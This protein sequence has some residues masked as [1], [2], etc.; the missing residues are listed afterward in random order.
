[1]I[2]AGFNPL[3]EIAR[4][5]GKSVGELKENLGSIPLKEVQEA[6]I[7]ATEAGGLFHGMLEK[8]AEGIAGVQAK[9]AGAI[10]NAFNKIGEENEGAIKA[11]FKLA[12][13]LIEQLTK[14]TPLITDAVVAFGAYKTA[15]I[16]TTTAE[17]AVAAAKSIHARQTAILRLAQLKLNA[18]IK[19]NPYGVA[20]ALLTALVFA[21]YKFVTAKTAAEKAQESF[22]K[23]LAD[24]NDL[25][26]ERRQKGDDA[27]A[28]IRDE[29]KGHLEQVQALEKLKQ[30]Y[31]G[32]FR[33]MDLKTAKTL[34]Q[35][36]AQRKLNDADKEGTLI[37]ARK[38]VE[39][40]KVEQ[41]HIAVNGGIFKGKKLREITAERK[42][43]EAHLKKLEEQAQ[44]ADALDTKAQAKTVREATKEYTEQIKAKREQI[45]ELRKATAT[46]DTA[47]IESLQKEI[48]DLEAK[49]DLL[50]GGGNKSGAASP[51]PSADPIEQAKK[52]IQARRAYEDLLSRQIASTISLLKDGTEKEVRQIEE[53]HRLKIQALERQQEDM[54]LTLKAEG[55]TLSE[56]QVQQF[57]DLKAQEQELLE[58]AVGKRVEADRLANEKI[59]DAY[60]TYHQKREQIL[61]NAAKKEEEIRRAA[62]ALGTDPGEHLE[63]LRKQTDEALKAFDEEQAQK[64]ATFR[65]WLKTLQTRTIEELKNA[66]KKARQELKKLEGAGTATA[67]ARAKVNALSEAIEE[68]EARE[69]ATADDSK[70]KWTDLAQ[71]LDDT[72][73][74]FDRLGTQIGGVAGAVIGTIGT[75]TTATTQAING[76][77][78]ITKAGAKGV[79]GTLK[80]VERASAILA[81]I[82]A[83]IQVAQK[84][85]SLFDRDKQK[86][87]EI[88][89]LQNDIDALRWELQNAQRLQ[90]LSFDKSGAVIAKYGQTLK[91]TQEDL[92]RANKIALGDITAHRDLFDILLTYQQKRQQAF[93]K[94]IA[95]S[96]KELDY[97]ITHA[98]GEERFKGVA[99]QI[100]NIAEQTAKLQQQMEA[101]RSKK[102]SDG[103]AIRSY[104]QQI[105]ENAL[106]ARDI[107]DK[108]TEDIM[109]GSASSI[110]G[111]LGDALLEAFKKGEDGAKAWGD[112]VKN[113][114]SDIVKRLM[115]SKLVEQPIGRIFD[116]YQKQWFGAN[117]EFRGIDAVTKS[118]PALAKELETAGGGMM[119]ALKHLS[120]ALEGVLK[121]ADDT[122]EAGET[123]TAERKGIATAGQDSIDELNGRATA[124]QGHTYTIQEQTKELRNIT[125]SIL[126]QVT[127]IKTN[128][129]T[130]HDIKKDIR[131]V[132]DTVTELQTKGIKTV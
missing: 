2:N 84:V 79:S 29:T 9:L 105:K 108:A 97:T 25:L 15:L 68:F 103:N 121:I 70:V 48:K 96:Y 14:L 106:K 76:I 85:A 132:R 56:E 1:M 62:E 120:P 73:R 27:L 99:K 98:L 34:S 72:A 12:N 78:V 87:E 93:A 119:E 89:G 6:F 107:I 21:I 51:K 74:A 10:Q 19:A 20:A 102:K 3:T 53:G 8:Q 81:V 71:T 18:A 28:V 94:A 90:N 59:L 95:T 24:E 13:G 88:K 127:A 47:K 30:L 31:P 23:S 35:V 45:K 22:N 26:T 83:V 116:K 114:V 126:S 42:L 109:G 4:K 104:E 129:D 60:L 123:R 66:L 100:D 86:D 52:E 131:G 5:T 37:A 50:T 63:E 46:A 64:E 57:A 65:A 101:E 128:T 11:G 39:E 58:Q 122:K 67:E 61:K 113:I 82:S 117:S 75:I 115:V 110:A 77:Q 40:L 49:R 91:K 32:I 111:K 55:K 44:Q 41:A 112:T 38:R 33:D 36:D 69:K 125:S 92:R 130:L 118:L 7:S 124:I 80:T 43:A 54:E 16:L 17:K